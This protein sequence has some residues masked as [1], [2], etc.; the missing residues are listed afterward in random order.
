LLELL[1]TS[2]PALAADEE[3]FL[4][5]VHAV[6]P[7]VMSRLYDPE[8][9]V[10]VEACRAL[11]ALCVAA[12][13]FL[14]SRFKTEWSDGLGNWFKR[15]KRQALANKFQKTATRHT[16]GD[17]KIMIPGADGTVVQAK[18]VKNEH[19]PGSL[20]Q[21]ASPVRLWES[22]V[23]LL[24]TLVLHVQISEEIFEDILGLLA[25]TLERSAEVREA[26]ETINADAVWLLRYEQGYIEPLATPQMEGFTF[27]PMSHVV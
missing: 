1:S 10:A 11:S 9:F 2:S 5:L 3:A 22:A 13:D 27:R 14:S 15:V 8:T 7:V 25:E 21:H 20:G 16:Y 4:P 17:D 19:S 23:G 18:S 26:L 6:W 12:G 24:T